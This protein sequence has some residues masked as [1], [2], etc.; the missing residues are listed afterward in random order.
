MLPQYLVEAQS[1]MYVG[2]EQD[3]LGEATELSRSLDE[4]QQLLTQIQANFSEVNGQAL[5]ECEAFGSGVDSFFSRRS[6]P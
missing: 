3:I 5:V 6:D 4:H 1:D 2:R